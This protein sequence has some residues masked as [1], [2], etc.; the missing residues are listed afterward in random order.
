MNCEKLVSVIMPVYNSQ[1]YVRDAIQSVLAQTYKNFELIIIDDGSTDNSGAI[2][3]EF[4]NNDRRITVVH[5]RNAGCCVARNKGIRL[6]RGAFITFIDNDDIYLSQYLEKNI[7]AFS[8]DTD[9]VK[10]GRKN[11]D[12]NYKEE[13][14]YEKI[15]KYHECEFSF[16]E[17]AKNYLDIRSSGI[18]SSVWNGIYRSDIVKN[19]YIFFKEDLKHGNE[20]IIFNAEYI[21]KCK[22]IHIC[23]DVLYHHYVRNGHS[24]SSKFYFD[25]LDTKMT[26][27]DYERKIMQYINDDVSMD[28]FNVIGLIECYDMW[29]KALSLEDKNRVTAYIQSN[30]LAKYKIKKKKYFIVDF[31]LQCVIAYILLSNKQL[32]IFS[33]LF[34][35]KKN[36]RLYWYKLRYEWWYVGNLLRRFC[37]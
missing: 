29:F 21:L 7:N 6:S 14:F 3:D 20:D 12:V 17:F 5:Q 22:K 18:L 28:K 23:K 27:L 9:L 2:C 16:N 8:K 25:Q 1:K 32:R 4:A 37:K 26:A 19:N 24:T 34:T 33:F 30:Y 36:F 35:I 15:L 11:I 31:P 10:C 13:V